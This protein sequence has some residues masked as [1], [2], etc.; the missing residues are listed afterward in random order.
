MPVGNSLKVAKFA[1]ASEEPPPYAYLFL[2][3]LVCQSYQILST[4]CI[5]RVSKV[6]GKEN[7]HEPHGARKIGDHSE[8]ISVP[9]SSLEAPLH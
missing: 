4:I 9:R 1:V 3:L 8:A 6:R 5:A 2:G 7:D